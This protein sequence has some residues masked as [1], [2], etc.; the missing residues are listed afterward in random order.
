[1]AFTDLLNYDDDDD[2]GDAD[3]CF[4]SMLYYISNRICLRHSCTMYIAIYFYK[5]FVGIH[6]IR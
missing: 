5:Y 4:L 6:P 1:M 2:D 3:Q